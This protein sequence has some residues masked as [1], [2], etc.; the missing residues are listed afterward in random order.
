M[1][2]GRAN[3]LARSRA[4]LDRP[5]RAKTQRPRRA[6]IQRRERTSTSPSL[7]SLRSSMRAAILAK[8]CVV[9]KETGEE[10]SGVRCGGARAREA[11][12]KEHPSEG[13]AVP[14]NTGSVGREKHEMKRTKEN[15]YVVRHGRDDA[16]QDRALLGLVAVSDG[17]YDFADQHEPVIQDHPGASDI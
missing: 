12:R 2:T 9:S 17:A 14:Q 1:L 6:K 10:S 15:T 13:V 3:A 4:N 5:R 11:R 8:A 16:R 7:R